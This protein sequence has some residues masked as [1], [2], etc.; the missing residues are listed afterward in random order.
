MS[1]HS[2]AA[3]LGAGRDTKV[4]SEGEIREYVADALGSLGRTRKE[5]A[6]DADTTPPAVK[7]WR[8]QRNTMSLTAFVRMARQNP[9]FQ[10][11]AAYLIG[12]EDDVLRHREWEAELAR[13]QRIMAEHAAHVS[14]AHA[15][16][17]KED[18]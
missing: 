6:R 12:I 3:K 16:R 10:K 8:E 11:F 2:A 18:Q 5:L 7:N 4:L 14:E 9:R 1:D 15:A 13:F 17:L